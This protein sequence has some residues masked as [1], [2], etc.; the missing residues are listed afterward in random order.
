MNNPSS[1]VYITEDK[2]R[3]LKFYFL[4]KSPPYI[5]KQVICLSVNFFIY[6]LVKILVPTF[7]EVS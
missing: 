2:N 5:L 4:V 3:V 6:R 7:S 1:K